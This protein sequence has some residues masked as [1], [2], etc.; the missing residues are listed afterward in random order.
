MQRAVLGDRH[1][2]L[3]NTMNNL[4]FLYYDEGRVT[5]AIAMLRDAHTLART[6]LGEDHPDVGAIATNLG[7]WLTQE[8]NYDE[9]LALL[10]RAL[11]IR[12]A[13]FGEETSAS[14]QLA[15]HQGQLA[16][17]DERL[18]RR[19]ATLRGKPA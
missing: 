1:P 11:E 7:F 14:R 9:A 2:D 17:R 13:A 8:G 12:K 18:S 19:R 6:A 10:D 15:Q 16:A 4:A 3:V 5:D